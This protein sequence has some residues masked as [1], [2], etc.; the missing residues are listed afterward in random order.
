MVKSGEDITQSFK[1]TGLNARRTGYA[2][3]AVASNMEAYNE[4]LKTA[5]EEI[6]NTDKLWEQTQARQATLAKQIEIFNNQ[7][8]V[9]GANS[10]AWLGN[11]STAA[12]E[13][14]NTLMRGVN[15]AV[16]MGGALSWIANTLTIGSTA[17]TGF[18]QLLSTLGNVS[19]SILTFN[20]AMKDDRFIVY[21]NPKNHMGQYR[22]PASGFRELEFF[23]QLVFLNRQKQWGI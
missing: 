14:V 12:M 8:E 18:F 19:M 6:T 10:A 17:A 15:E 11:A 23:R 22:P 16:Q 2:Y 21:F 3:L 20:W 9:L 5:Q 4:A 7:L 1:D 13:F